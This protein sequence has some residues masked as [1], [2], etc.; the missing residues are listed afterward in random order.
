MV[1]NQPPQMKNWR[2]IIA[3]RRVRVSVVMRPSSPPLAYHGAPMATLSRRG[4][5]E[6]SG[7]WG[8]SALLAP[9]LPA[10]V[11]ATPLGAAGIQLYAVK[12]SLAADPAATLRR[13]RGI[14]F[15]E[16]ETAG[17]AGLSAR[18]FRRLLDDN[19]LVAPSAHLDFS[20]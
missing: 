5:L 6:H 11:E 20:D 17:F 14:G 18:D 3:H 19:G 12:D 9:A 16:V 13:V 15:R 10:V 1:T 4:F 2:N 7:L 8:L